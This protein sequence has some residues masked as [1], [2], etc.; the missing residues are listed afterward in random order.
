MPDDVA[1]AVSA[2]CC[3][4]RVPSEITAP[5][6]PSPGQVTVKRNPSST[7]MTVLSGLCGL[8]DCG[9]VVLPR[10][11]FAENVTGCS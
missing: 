9:T 7:G 2:S 4:R 5:S 6:Q 10:K 8:G 3:V 11:S 1:A